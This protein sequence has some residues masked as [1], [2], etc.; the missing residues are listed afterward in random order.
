[1]KVEGGGGGRAAC[2]PSC[3]RLPVHFN[4]LPYGGHAPSTSRPWAS[5]GG[6]GRE[7]HRK[8]EIMRERE[9]AMGVKGGGGSGGHDVPQLPQSL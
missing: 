9:E 1:M 3:Q 7:P 6:R 8:Q 2:H 5:V 4:R